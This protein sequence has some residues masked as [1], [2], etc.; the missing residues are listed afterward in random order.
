MRSEQEAARAIELYADTVRRICMLHLKSDSDTED[1][2][3]TVFL[4]YVLY[5]GAFENEEHEKAWLI[6]VT[7]N[8]CK[9]FMKSFF[10]SRTVPLDEIEELTADVPEDH[11]DVLEAVL[12]LPVKYKT[13]VYLY[14]YEQ[15]SAVEISKL[16]EKNVNTVYT[17]LARAKTMLKERLGG[18]EFE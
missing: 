15:Y 11:S 4:K 10:R 1:I 12:S 2:F 5:S 17:L 8:A 13:V 9:D 6:R 3:Q 14:F 18:E 7:L 16:L